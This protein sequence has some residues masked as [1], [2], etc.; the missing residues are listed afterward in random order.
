MMIKRIHF[1]GLYPVFTSYLEITLSCF[2][3]GFAGVSMA[4]R[5]SEK[6]RNFK[7]WTQSDIPYSHFSS[8]YTGPT[9]FQQLQISISAVSNTNKKEQPKTTIY[10]K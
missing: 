3:S 9:K 1:I 5:K 2:P 10:S 6:E 7:K 8:T 4:S